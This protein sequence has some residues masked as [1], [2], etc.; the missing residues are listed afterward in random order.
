MTNKPTRVATKNSAQRPNAE[1][2]LRETF[3]DELHSQLGCLGFF[4]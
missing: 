1:E 4:V 3:V 2:S